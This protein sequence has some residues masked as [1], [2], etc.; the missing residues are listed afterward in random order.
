MDKMMKHD[1]EVRRRAI[2][3]AITVLE[4]N[5]PFPDAEGRSMV[6]RTLHDRTI[7]ELRK[8]QQV[9]SVEEYLALPGA[10][11]L[12]ARV[13]PHMHLVVSCLLVSIVMVYATITVMNLHRLAVLRHGVER[14]SAMKHR[15]LRD[16]LDT[17]VRM[18]R[19]EAL[20]HPLRTARRLGK[21]D[22][23]GVEFYY[24]SLAARGGLMF[25]DGVE[26]TQRDCELLDAVKAHGLKW[27]EPTYDGR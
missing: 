17:E 27:P 5:S 7:G 18:V 16:L 23:P 9:G 13:V 26:G 25:E 6:V 12:P 14:M 24:E 20:W 8:L 21:W 22:R 19:R 1:R 2:E 11:G 3:D 10:G 15:V 4:L